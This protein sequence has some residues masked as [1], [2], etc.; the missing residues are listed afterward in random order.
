MKIAFEVKEES[1]YNCEFV[2]K[3]ER[4][5]QDFKNGKGVRMSVEELDALWK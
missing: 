5:K 2:A 4:S 1:P 3:I